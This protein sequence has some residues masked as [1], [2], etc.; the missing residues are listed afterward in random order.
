[1][2][3]F[4]TLNP[5]DF[6][7]PG[8]SLARLLSPTLVIC[9]DHVRQN[10]RRV[11]EHLGG[12]ASR[13]RPHVKTMKIPAVYAEPMRFGVRA[14]KCATTREAA[15]LL[16]VMR[17]EE[18]DGGDL[19]VAYPHVGPALDRIRQLAAAYPK[20]RV[21]VLCD[22]ARALDEIPPALG[23]FVDVNPGMDRTGLPL[24]RAAE[25]IDIARRAGTR[26]RGVHFYEGHIVDTDAQTRRR[27]AFEGYDR[28][29]SLLDDLAAA[30]VGVEEV[31]TSGTPT[32]LDALAY[33][34]LAGR[35]GII[36]RVSP[37]TVIYHDSRSEQR[38][39]EL[40]LQP[41]ALVLTR[42]VSRPADGIITCDAGSKSIAAEAGHPCAFVLGHPQLVPLVPSEEHLPLEVRRGP[43]PARGT[44]LLLIPRHV[45]PTVNLAEHAVL[46]EAGHITEIAPVS[47]RA[48][49]VSLEAP[50]G[51]APTS[52]ATGQAP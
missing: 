44:E 23:I 48:H 7:L 14:F 16:E 10:I 43:P 8:A 33:P 32:F 19:L 21:S 52:G 25:I 27:K 46:V 6:A 41:A 4:E 45:C 39:A 17:E 1:M 9:L 18:I 31:I 50:E 47:A 51:A 29:V 30:G 36:H 5:L 12:A 20:T 2:S 15:C 24:S 28:L 40:D 37:G 42:V 3:R 35:D 26:F 22:E 34:P 11:I 13:W 38:I 49:E